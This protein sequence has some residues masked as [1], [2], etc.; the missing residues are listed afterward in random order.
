MNP[1]GRFVE[2]GP[3]ADTGLTGRKLMVDTYG[4]LG[5]HGGGAFSGKD[6]SKVDRSAAYM[7]R[8]IACTIVDAGLAARV[9]GGG[10]APGSPHRCDG[11]V[12]AG[13]NRSS[14]KTRTP[15]KCPT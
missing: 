15:L 7:A 4:G 14:P 6:S 9:S 2:G 12:V 5:S 1:S 8:L 13:G 11:G 3:R 10:A